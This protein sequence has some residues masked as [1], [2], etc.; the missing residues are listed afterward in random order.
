MTACQPY[1]GSPPE[2]VD[3][4]VALGVGR[5]L[6]GQVG[7]VRG[8]VVLTTTYSKVGPKAQIKA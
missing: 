2:T 8:D 6:L 5:R 4:E 7:G 3:V 1:V